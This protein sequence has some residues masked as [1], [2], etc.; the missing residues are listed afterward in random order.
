[1]VTN[2]QIKKVLDRFDSMSM[3][4]LKDIGSLKHWKEFSLTE[5]QSEEDIR[6]CAVIDAETKGKISPICYSYISEHQKMTDDFVKE[7]MFLTSCLYSRETY[8]PENI[9]IVSDIISVYNSRK[10]N[11]NEQWLY[12]GTLI[13]SGVVSES[14]IKALSQC[15]KNSP[16]TDRL[17]WYGIAKNNKYLTKEFID[18]FK[19]LIFTTPYAPSND[20]I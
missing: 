14:L 11:I 9:E 5:N 13:G 3:E 10:R 6:L 18:H 17:D 12:I 2:E 8:T 16:I 1:M 4:E 15:R 7:L 19:I 20:D